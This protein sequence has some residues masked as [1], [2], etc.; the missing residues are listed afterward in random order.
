MKHF[1]LTILSTI[2]SIIFWVIFGNLISNE[3]QITL[4]V[5]LAVLLIISCI[6][7]VEFRLMNRFN[8]FYFLLEIVL[9]PISIIRQL[10]F[11]IFKLLA[12][13]KYIVD[14][15]IS[16]L[17]DNLTKSQKMTQFLFCFYRND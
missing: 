2:Q 4:L 10:V 1:L 8:F 17:N 9:T 6:G 16:S 5:I 11:F 15:N 12:N 7:S 3:K 14:E 13:P